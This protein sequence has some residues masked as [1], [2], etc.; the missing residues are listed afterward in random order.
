MRALVLAGGAGSRLRPITHTQAKQLIP[1]ANVPILFHV[2]GQIRDAGI[3]EVGIVTGSTGAEVR[4]AV[5]DG[6]AGGMQATYIPQA[7]P[8][9]IAHAVLTAEDYVRGA[10]FLLFLGDN[11]LRDGVARFVRG[12]ETHAPDAQILLTRVPEPEHFGV[13]VVEGERVVRLVEKP[14][15]FIS[16][17]ALVGVYL[18]RDSVLDACRTLAPSGRGEYEI[19]EAIQWLID[20]GRAV[21]AEMVDG[22]WK[23]TGRPEDLLDANRLLLATATARVDGTVDAASTVEGVVVVEPGARIARSR[24]RG[25]LVVGRDAV[26]EDAELGP[27]VAL[28]PGCVVRRSTIEDSILMRDCRIEGVRLRGS[29]LGRGVEVTGAGAGV[30]HRL[31]L[32][33]QSQVEVG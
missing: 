25:P 10:P 1:V 33:D 12:F 18:F 11:L 28:S 22:W 16:D 15:T 20:E 2:L 26:V 21:R 9:G 17:I 32:G 29:L 5:G 4:A 7:E 3:D 13:A 30:V 14:T 27:D 31:V 6:S 24:L 23:D 8:L 19:T